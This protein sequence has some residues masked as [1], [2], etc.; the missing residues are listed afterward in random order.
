MTGRPRRHVEDDIGE[1]SAL[2]DGPVK[3]GQVITTIDG[4]GIDDDV[5]DR[6]IKGRGGALVGIF[7]IDH[8]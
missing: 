4:G 1:L 3:K 2:A 6:N 5:F 7:A 8:G